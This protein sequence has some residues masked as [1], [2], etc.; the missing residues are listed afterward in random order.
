MGGKDVA[1]EDLE[2]YAWVDKVPLSRK[3]SH[4]AR[5]FADAFLVAEVLRHYA[6]KLNVEVNIHIFLYVG[7]WGGGCFVDVAGLIT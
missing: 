4:F 3:K 5:D 7:G 6:P 1:T 2:V